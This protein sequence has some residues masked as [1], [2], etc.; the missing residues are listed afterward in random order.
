MIAPADLD[1]LRA[2]AAA[3]ERPV[4]SVYLDVDQSRAANLKRGFAVELSTRL[5]TVE[6]QLAE[7]EREPFRA[8][9]ALVERLVG[10]HEPRAKTVVVFADGGAAPLCSGDLNVALPTDVRWRGAPFMRPL[11]EAIDEYPRS[12]IVLTD[13]AQARLFVAFLGDIEE[14]GEA[15]APG[16]VRRKKASG[17]DHL[18]SDM[19]FQRQD[20][21]HV[22][23]HLRGVADRLEQVAAAHDLERVVLAGSLEA[24][25]ELARLLPGALAARVAGILRLPIDASAQQLLEHALVLVAHAEREAEQARVTDLLE[26][27]RVGLDAT[28]SAFQDGRLLALIY[29]EGFVAPGSECPRCRAL[30]ATAPPDCAYCGAPPRSLDDLVERVI[31]RVGESGA[32][33]EQVRGDAAR[34]LRDVGGIGAL[35]RF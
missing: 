22:H 11:I 2:R 15:I 13:K 35:L 7:S 8:A 21:M 34:R 30:L 29:A 25:N 19:H 10:Q 17:S 23:W 26:R 4:L 27:G 1:R 20:E 24:T 33:V 18:R 16:E 14:I 12:A 31:E 28:V 3:S 5:R 6:Q 32:S 9:A